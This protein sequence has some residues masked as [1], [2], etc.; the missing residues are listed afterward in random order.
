LAKYADDMRENPTAAERKLCERLT[1]E[2]E[3]R[4]ISVF[5]QFPVDSY[6]LD[7][8]IP[9]K[10]LAIEVDGPYHYSPEQWDKD[11]SR[12]SKLWKSKHI[13]VL[14]FDN[15]EIHQT[16]NAVINKI[17]RFMEKINA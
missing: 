4:G 10:M 1:Q 16:P 7:L 15:E 17:L 3:G 12:T 11:F 13:R 9:D 14:R 5:C 6:I 2:L 8:F